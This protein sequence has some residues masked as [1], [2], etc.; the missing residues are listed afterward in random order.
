MFV[1]IFVCA[2]AEMVDVRERTS[3]KKHST[4]DGKSQI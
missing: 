1:F 4:Q 2:S 3:S